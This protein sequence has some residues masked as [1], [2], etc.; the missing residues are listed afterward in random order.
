MGRRGDGRK[1]IK[2]KK[3]EKVKPNHGIIKAGKDL[4]PSVDLALPWSALN[5][6]APMSPS[7]TSTCFQHMGVGCLDDDSTTSLGKA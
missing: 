2:R 7:A 3:V 1:F 6:S 4:N 5:P